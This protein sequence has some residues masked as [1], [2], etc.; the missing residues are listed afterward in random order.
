MGFVSG[1]GQAM[2]SVLQSKG[3]RSLFW[4]GNHTFVGARFLHVLEKEASFV[5][6]LFDSVLFAPEN[7]NSVLQQRLLELAIDLLAQVTV[8]F[9]LGLFGLL[10][11]FWLLFTLAADSALF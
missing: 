10:F 11:F 1:R 2:A 7:M 3:Q 8:V 5:P 4:T 6:F 9:F